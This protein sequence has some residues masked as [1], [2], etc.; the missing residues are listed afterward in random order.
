MKLRTIILPALAVI[1]VVLFCTVLASL[2]AVTLYEA[3]EDSFSAEHIDPSIRSLMT[4]EESAMILP[5]ME[6]LMFSCRDVIVEL[7]AGDIEYFKR[8]LSSYE[9]L[10][11]RFKTNLNKIKLSGTDLETFRLSA[12]DVDK[13]LAILGDD[14]ER[15]L[16]L[17][18]KRKTATAAERAIIDN[19]LKLIAAEAVS[20]VTIFSDAA[21]SMREIAEE[22]GLDTTG[23]KEAL[24]QL[25]PANFNVEEILSILQIKTPEIQLSSL[26]YTINPVSGVYGDSITLTGK[27]LPKKEINI[28]WGSNL[29]KNIASDTNGAFTAKLKIE[30]IPAGEHVVTLSSEKELSKPTRLTVF[31]QN[32]DIKILSVEQKEKDGEKVVTIKGILTTETEVPVIDAQISVI[33]D[34]FGYVFAS[35]KSADKGIWE[36]AAEVSE[37]TYRVYAQFN[38]KRFPLFESRSEIVEFTIDPIFG[39]RTIDTSRG[40]KDIGSYYFVLI[41]LIAA[42]GFIVWRIIRRRKQSAGNSSRKPEKTSAKTPR[43]EKTAEKEIDPLIDITE[44]E[45]AAAEKIYPAEDT[46]TP[47]SYPAGLSAAETMREIY[48]CVIYALANKYTIEHIDAK[49]PREICAL[50]TPASKELTL[51]MNAYEYFRYSGVAV[52]DTDLAALKETA[53]AIPELAKENKPQEDT[54]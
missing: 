6:D 52:T 31:P 24:E 36:A 50:F 18:E 23:L 47:S 51:F 21:E 45:I 13:A 34:D 35:G 17:I 15:V 26:I 53:A 27:T 11:S 1:A 49:T 39:V 16:K 37:G 8:E 25:N 32:T 28:Y 43:A 42:A 9:N 30:K 7:S 5:M 48:R 29:W 22:Y 33:G 38:D 41:I 54:P 10:L 12:D 3:K 4:T 40:E 2:P 44:E 20:T 14:Y 46:K 19:E